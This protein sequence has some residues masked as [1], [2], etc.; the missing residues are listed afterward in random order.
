[1]VATLSGSQLCS[2]AR[3][4]PCTRLG[5]CHSSNQIGACLREPDESSALVPHQ[6]AAGSRQLQAGLDFGWRALVVKQKRP[7]DLLD[8]DA[9][10][11]RRFEAVGDL[12]RFAGGLYQIGVSR[13]DANF[14]ISRCYHC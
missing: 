6:P 11:L 12:K 13:L 10:V 2:P 9:A 7:V 1:M 8:V 3:T 5:C 4:D 14:I